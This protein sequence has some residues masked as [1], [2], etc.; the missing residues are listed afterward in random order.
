MASCRASCS[1]PM[2]TTGYAWN[3]RLRHCIRCSMP[4]VSSR[5]FSG[6]RGIEFRSSGYGRVSPTEKIL[7]L[8]WSIHQFTVEF[9]VG[10]AIVFVTIRHAIVQLNVRFELNKQRTCF[11]PMVILGVNSARTRKHVRTKSTRSLYRHWEK[12]R[13]VTLVTLTCQPCFFVR[14]IYLEKEKTD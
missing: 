5:H 2:K 10:S 4:W 1:L 7:K 8:R 3:R 9:I 14:S 6:T 12:K 11:S 13:T